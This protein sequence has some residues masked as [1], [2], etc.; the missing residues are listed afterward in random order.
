MMQLTRHAQQ[1]AEYNHWMNQ[2]LYDACRKLTGEQL[3]ENRGA[4]FGS[5]LGTLNHI[6][7]GDILWLKRF[8]STGLSTLEVMNTIP[9]PESLNSIVFN[10]LQ[11]LKACREQLDNIILAFTQQITDSELQR[12]LTYKNSKGIVSNKMLF[13]L[14]MHLFNHQ[15]HHRGQISTLLSQCGIDIGVTDLVAIIPNLE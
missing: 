14:L 2:K 3:A 5:I 7:V 6:V 1:M 15:T 9:T 11:D 8:S 4:F 13:N 12:V 10:N